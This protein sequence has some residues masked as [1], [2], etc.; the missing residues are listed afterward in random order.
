MASPGRLPG[1]PAALT[2]LARGW[3][4]QTT[5]SAMSNQT[6]ITLL[7][8]DHKEVSGLLK[9]ASATSDSATAKRDDLFARISEALSAHM[10]FEEERVYPVLQRKQETRD[11]ALEAIE[12]HQQAKQ[13]LRDL[14]GIASD[15]ERW[16]A[17]VTVLM[18]DIKHHVKEEEQ[19]GGLFSELESALEQAELVELAKEYAETKG[20]GARSR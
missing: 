6:I 3:L 17:K 14:A 10:A 5:R 7:K 20:L 19:A 4:D 1:G 16:K 8:K 15:D 18:E 13:L 12:E 11:T 9:Q 2:T